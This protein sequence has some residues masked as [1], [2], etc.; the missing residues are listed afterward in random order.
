MD[1]RIESDGTLRITPDPDEI[2]LIKRWYDDWL[3][4]TV[5]L[6]IHTGFPGSIGTESI[7]QAERVINPSEYP[8]TK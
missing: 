4:G 5:Q 1:A 3:A 7:H 2:Y 8:V 6:V